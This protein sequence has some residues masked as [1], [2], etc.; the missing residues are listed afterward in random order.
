VKLLLWSR[1]QLLKVEFVLVFAFFFHVC[2]IAVFLGLQF[3][4]SMVTMNDSLNILNELFLVETEFLLFLGGRGWS[5]LL[6]LL[7]ALGVSGC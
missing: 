7:F 6:L 4:V 3:R 5:C 1:C 2:D